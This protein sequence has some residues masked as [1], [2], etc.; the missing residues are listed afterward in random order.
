MVI[1]CTFYIFHIKI[2]SYMA[3]SKR[4]MISKAFCQLIQRI[5]VVIQNFFL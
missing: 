4:K 5:Y 1:Q 3:M 2:H